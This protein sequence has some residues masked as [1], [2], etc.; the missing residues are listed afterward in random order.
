[1]K[2]IHVINLVLGFCAERSQRLLWVLTYEDISRK[3]REDA[4]KW[5]I[6][7]K[8]IYKRTSISS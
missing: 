4:L 2:N 7:M 8:I 1:M 6:R 5:G 3:P